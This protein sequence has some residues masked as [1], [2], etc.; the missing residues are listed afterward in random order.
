MVHLML[1]PAARQRTAEKRQ[2]ISRV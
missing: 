1:W 2:W